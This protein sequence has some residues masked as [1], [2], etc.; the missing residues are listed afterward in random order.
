MR[1]SVADET[2]AYDPKSAS[3]Y[4]SLHLSAP[5]RPDM[6][7]MK[8][9]VLRAGVPSASLLVEFPTDANPRLLIQGKDDALLFST[10]RP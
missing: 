4:G 6:P 10:E 3:G 5:T 1:S 2:T 9:P 7:G 8:S